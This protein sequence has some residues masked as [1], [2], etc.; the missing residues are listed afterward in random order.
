MPHYNPTIHHRKSI[1]L[2]G[3][4]YA[5]AGLYFMTICCHGRLCRFGKIENNEMILNEYG[6]IAFNTWEMLPQQFSNLELDVFQIMPNHIHGII[7]LTNNVGAGFTPALIN[8]DEPQKNIPTIPN[9]VGIYKSLVAN[10]CLS[11][12]KSKNEIMGKFWQRNYYE[13]IIRNEQSHQRIADYIINNPAKWTEDKFYT[14]N[15]CRGVL[16]TP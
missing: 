14:N 9:I 3:Y 10:N 15:P 11:I 13:H 1:R 5:Q 2:K 6:Q 8:K 4:D 7:S 16:H 12:C